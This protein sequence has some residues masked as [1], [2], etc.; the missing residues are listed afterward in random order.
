MK[1]Q[2]AS[3]LAVVALLI[4]MPARAA[5][6]VKIG[7]I[8]TLSGPGGYL[9]EDVR[10]GFQLAIDQEQGKR[11]SVPVRVIVEDD[12]LKPGN[13]KQIAKRLLDSEN[14]KIFTGI[15]F[16]NVAV[17]VVPD[18][19]DGSAFYIGA[20]A[21][22]SNFAGKDCDKNYF[23]VNWQND[24]LHEA[25]GQAATELGFQKAMAVV[26]NYQGGLDALAG[27]KRRFKGEV[28]SE[29]F[30][31]LDQ[32]DF[33]GEMAQIR[34]TKPNV[35]YQFQPGGLG[36]AFLKQYAQAGLKE[37]I[38][39]VVAAPSMD[40]RIMTAVGDAA[41]GV[42][43]ATFWNTDFDNPQ[44]KRFVAD[45]EA[46]YHRLPTFY[47][48]QGYDAAQLVASAL[49]AVDGDAGKVDA[50]RMALR[51]ADFMSVRGPFRFGPNQHPI[52][53]W[54]AARVETGV[55]GKPAIRTKKKILEN[56][57]DSYSAACKM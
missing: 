2:S 41:I 38:P 19:L 8:T 52:Q 25:A 28:V 44:S 37:T 23:V 6:P 55:D 57:G 22:P 14:V 20:N 13:A 50:F 32:T 10:D 47:A 29:L 30:T 40:N 11:G 43:L 17:A 42:T 7:M 3:A 45:F 5:E 31:K 35:V 1:A 27:F 21:A 24:A 54:Y 26:P 56:F 34:A 12:A 39:M 51:K 49:K 16:T 33:A 53:D 4:G 48:A 36:I 15:I 9:G 18:I 46:K